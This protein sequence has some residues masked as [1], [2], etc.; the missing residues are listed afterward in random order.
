MKYL[1]PLIPAIP[2]VAIAYSLLS[3]DIRAWIAWSSLGDE[4]FYMAASIILIYLADP[5]TGYFL[6]PLILVS[7]SANLL[8]KNTI[9]A[10]RP[11]NP[12]VPVEGYSLPSGHAQVSASFW[13]A[14][15]TKLRDPWLTLASALIVTGVSLSRIFLRAHRVEDVVAGVAVG[16]ALAWISEKTVAKKRL[17]TYL[18][19]SGCATVLL[20]AS[21]YMA[22]PQASTTLVALASLG[23]ATAASSVLAEKSAAVIK[24][25]GIW[26]RL[27]AAS[28]ILGLLVL[29]HYL[30]KNNL[31]AYAAG[32]MISGLLI[33]TPPAILDALRKKSSRR[34]DSGAAGI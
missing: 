16:L 20:A 25:W 17:R 29:T 32:L 28:I 1:K 30:A 33:Y 19:A 4:T 22:E 24:Q 15:A 13:G 8:L 31:Y 27:V 12:L 9:K 18:L 2:L 23:A 10:P 11:S 6:A 26:R 14:L 21:S 34:E 3:S 7:G 5:H